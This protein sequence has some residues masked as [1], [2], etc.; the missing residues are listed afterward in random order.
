MRISTVGRLLGV[1][2]DWIR[3]LERSGRI[4]HA[5]RDLNGHRRFTEAEVEHLRA[6]LFGK[7][8]DERSAPR[9]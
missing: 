7:R 5:P 8:Q 3:R 4:P 2:S 9:G 6:L 1:S